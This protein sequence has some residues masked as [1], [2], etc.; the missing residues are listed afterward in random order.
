[1]N[2]SGRNVKDEEVFSEEKRDLLWE[3]KTRLCRILGRWQGQFQETR[4]ESGKEE[5]REEGGKEEGGKEE[6]REEGAKEEGREEDG[7]VESGEDRQEGDRRTEAQE[8][9]IR[10]FDFTCSPEFDQDVGP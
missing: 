10:F 1:L 9:A 7:K 6:G 4:K 2:R 8:P 5:G 3:K